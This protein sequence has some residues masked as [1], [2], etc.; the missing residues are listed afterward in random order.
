MSREASCECEG[1]LTSARRDAD[2]LLTET[3]RKAEDRRVTSLRALDLELEGMAQRERERAQAEASR[4]RLLMEEALVEAVFERAGEDLAKL[5][6]SPAFASTLQA[7]LAEAMN[8]VKGSVRV[9]VAPVHVATCESWLRA[10]GHADTVV[11][12]DSSLLDGIAIEDARRSF[13]VTNT[14][15]NRLAKLENAARGRCISVLFADASGGGKA[16][17]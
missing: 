6:A 16:Q 9:L 10:N 5:A 4:Q 2:A 8:V 3:R 15:T 12:P 17:S 14:L 1:I 13:R 11:M 7:L